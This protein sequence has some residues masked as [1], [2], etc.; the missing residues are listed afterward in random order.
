MSVI[1]SKLIGTSIRRTD[2]LDKVLGTTHYSQDF[3]MEG[4]LYSGVLRSPHP[5]ALQR[6]IA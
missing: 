4:M 3:W 5:N 6:G 1:S 2:V